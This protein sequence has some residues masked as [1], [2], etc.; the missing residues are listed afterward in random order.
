[1]P[2]LHLAANG[3]IFKTCQKL[4]SKLTQ[5]DLSKQNNNEAV[6]HYGQKIWNIRR[7]PVC[8]NGFF[9]RAA[10]ER[11]SL[12][13][14]QN[15]ASEISKSTVYVTWK[16]YV[17]WLRSLGMHLIIKSYFN[18]IPCTTEKEANDIIH[19]YITLW[20]WHAIRKIVIEIHAGIHNYTC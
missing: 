8:I 11:V 10:K 17:F 2:E 4:N 20:Y 18:V 13:F 5:T 6:E 7:Y 9:D 1:M 3:H 16:Y 15:T 14:L 19:L 12:H